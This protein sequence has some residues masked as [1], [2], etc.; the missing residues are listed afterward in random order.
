[1]ENEQKRIIIR[2]TRP[3]FTKEQKVGFAVIIGVGCIALLLGGLYLVRHI[4]SPFF[5]EYSGDMYISQAQQDA[6]EK[7][8]QKAKDTDGD[9]LTDYDELYVYGSSPYLMDTDG[10][11][12]TDPT[13]VANKTNPACA[14][15]KDCS[16]MDTSSLTSGLFD[17]VLPVEDSSAS[18]S[19]PSLEEI[20]QAIHGLTIEEIRSLLVEAGADEQSLAGIS[21]EDLQAMFLDVMSDLEGSQDVNQP[22]E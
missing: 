18:V 11:G 21:D 13:E 1:M 19:T 15:G 3:S 2:R 10:D 22:F 9:G 8:Q 7:E 12:Y 20:Q 16:G 4:A 6:L 14:V 5:I 17:D